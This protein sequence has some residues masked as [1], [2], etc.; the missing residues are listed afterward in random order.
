MTIMRKACASLQGIKGQAPAPMAIHSAFCRDSIPGKIYV[1][2]RRRESVIEALAGIVGVYARTA[3]KLLLVPIEEMADLLKFTK[4]EH[5]LKVGAWVR[6]KQGHHTG[7][8]A[9]VIEVGEN[10][11]EV[12]IKFVPRIDMNPSEQDYTEDKRGVKRQR[13]LGSGKNAINKRPQ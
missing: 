11:E 13:N 4:I 6:F 7:D 9:Q 12:R 1:E 8:L 5:E 3:D 10:G 2:S